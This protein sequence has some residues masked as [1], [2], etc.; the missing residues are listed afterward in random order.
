MYWLIAFIVVV[1]LW[2]RQS[3]MVVIGVTVLM[4]Y[5]LFADAH[6]EYLLYDL[7]DALNRDTLLAVPVFVLA[8]A[9][10]SSGVGARRLTTLLRVLS[11]PLPIGLAIGSLL[12][13]VLVSAL[14]GSPAI[15]LL[16]VGPTLNRALLDQGYGA[17]FSIGLLCSGAIVGVLLPL[18]V[19]LILYSAVSQTEIFSLFRLAA[20]VALSLVLVLVVYSACTNWHRARFAGFSGGLRK[21]WAGALPALLSVAVLVVALASARLAPA[22]CGLL[23]LAAAL[24]AE[25]GFYGGLS[26]HKAWDALQDAVQQ[27][28]R[29]LPLVL[30]SVSLGAY[31]LY[32]Q[33]PERLGDWLVMHDFGSGQ[34][35]GVVNFALFVTGLLLDAVSALLLVTPLLAPAAQ[36]LGL[37]PEPFG[38]MVVLNL[39]LGYLTPPNG[40]V[41]IAAMLAFRESFNA[42]LAAVV[43]FM[44]VLWAGVLVLALVAL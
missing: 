12:S 32:Q 37:A 11:S 31:L 36:Q 9:L 6:A 18:S 16:A 25:G 22:H 15:A 20:I 28:G 26:K 24:I 34:F 42:V 4:L 44:A 7:W 17:S 2:L 29:I 43:P 40:L 23:F 13:M 19:P 30:F 3:L 1:L 21:A 5:T 27:L 14:C 8:H 39:S 38:V 33:I 35:L 41:L 10:M